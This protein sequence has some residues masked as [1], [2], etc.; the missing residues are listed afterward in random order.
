M[1]LGLIRGG[2]VSLV[3]STGPTRLAPSAIPSYEVLIDI[4][5][6]RLGRINLKDTGTQFISET[7]E[8]QKQIHFLWRREEK[9]NCHM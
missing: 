6:R 7:R 8:Q 1:G 2:G 5:L 9:I 3:T 4:C